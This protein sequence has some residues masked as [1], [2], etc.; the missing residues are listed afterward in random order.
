MINETELRE[1]ISS[2]EAQSPL[3]AKF[4]NFYLTYI[5]LLREKKLIDYGEAIVQAIRIL[6]G[7][8][9]QAQRWSNRFKWIF[10]DEYQDTSPAQATLLQLLGQQANLFVVGD[11]YQSIYSWQGSDPDNLRRF[12]V[13]F[14]NTAS[15]YLSKN[16]RCFPKLVRMSMGFLEK[17]GELHGVRVEYDHKRS[18]ED[19]SVYFLK[20]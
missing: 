10:C 3:M 15:Y 5:E 11:S 13:D 17:A 7:N 20:T 8:K 19:Q 2:L 12:E 6:R 14:P 1:S 4:A 16:Y 18:T 9:D